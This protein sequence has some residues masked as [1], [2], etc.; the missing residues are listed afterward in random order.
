MDQE[1][2]ELLYH[3]MTVLSEAAIGFVELD[4]K[5][6]IYKY[7][8][9][10]LHKLLGD[11]IVIINEFIQS[12]QATITKHIFGVS[13]TVDRVLFRT[14]IRPNP[15]KSSFPISV[16][17]QRNLISK[18]LIKVQDGLF[19]IGQ[20]RFPR[21]LT[22]VAE[23]SASITGA[24][25][26]GFSWKGQLF[27]NAV[28]LLRH[29]NKLREKSIEAFLHQAAVALQRHRTELELRKAHAELEIKVEERTAD[30]K[31]AMRDLEKFKLAV[32]NASDLIVITDA[33]SNIIYAN[34]A[35]STMTGYL[36]K[37]IIGKTPLFWG[38]K[39]DP[40][41]GK[42]WDTVRRTRKYAIK[43]VR[44][45]R[46]NSQGYIAETQV[47]PVL[48]AEMN[49]IFCVYIERD[50]TKAKE[51][52]QAKS[53]FVS[54][55]SHQL[56]APLTSVNWYTEAILNGD[57]GKINDEQKKYISEISE[58]NHRMIKLVSSLLNVSRIDM[59]TFMI[60][61]EPCD[62]IEIV[63]SVVLELRPKITEKKLEVE[64]NYIK[65]NK[66]MIDPNLTRIIFQNLISNAV[67][68]TQEGGKI[69]IAVEIKKDSQP[70]KSLL[71]TVK[72][73]GF[74]IPKNQQDKVFTKL[75]RADNIKEKVSEGTG[76]GLYIVK[77]ILDHSGGEIKFYSKQH[78]GTAFFVTL[79]FS[80]MPKKSGSRELSAT[81]L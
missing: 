51:I 77:S 6:D 61:P 59:G 60:E 47:A 81:K 15:F 1:P 16:S 35:T 41:H 54:L 5:S 44:N 37:E 34:D 71:I 7:I 48:D 10:N 19:G 21:V 72:D 70:R 33:G 80:G 52:D 26:L 2:E 39:S 64:E 58:A 4:Y 74:G 62:L 36:N 75:F 31:E 46:K 65:I 42:I 22:K 53:E 25:T 30:L 79:P 43:E 32:E 38:D 11:S 17:A 40:E 9:E 8:G 20:G 13:E 49:I 27:G 67:K 24:Y 18:R 78:K 23:L 12:E 76:L 14:L 69:Y 57:T 66:V 55:A 28:V 63:K 50:I 68:Y 56:R 29:G 45:I 3:D 73:N